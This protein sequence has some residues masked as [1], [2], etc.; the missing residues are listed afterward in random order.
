M[1]PQPLTQALLLASS[2]QSIFIGPENRESDSDR[3]NDVLECSDPALA[4]PV[5]NPSQGLRHPRKSEQVDK[6]SGCCGIAITKR[7]SV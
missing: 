4:A 5:G 1:V 7:S 3:S 2:I 6:V